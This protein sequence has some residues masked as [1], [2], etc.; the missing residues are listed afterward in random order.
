MKVYLDN[1]CYNRPYDDQTYTSIY[2][3]SQAKLYIQDLIRNGQL[4]LITS[5]ILDFENSEN[6]F[7]MRRK[8]IKDFINTHSSIY[9]SDNVRSQV[10]QKADDIKKTGIKHKDAC[11][12]ASAIIAGADYFPSTDH[13]LLK[14]KT[15]EIKMMN[16]TE[17]VKELEV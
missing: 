13:R 3:E 4:E 6:P 15:D 2:L 16:P 5:Y 1:C 14:Y 10:E 11:H 8:T 9:V 12:V 7:D 17:F